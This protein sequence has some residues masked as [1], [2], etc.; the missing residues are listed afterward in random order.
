MPAVGGHVPFLRSN[1]VA[2]GNAGIVEDPREAVEQ[3]LLPPEGFAGTR[4]RVL[5]LDYVRWDRS[6]E[7]E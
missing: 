1:G 5:L 3:G 4:L 7:R 2:P 6:R